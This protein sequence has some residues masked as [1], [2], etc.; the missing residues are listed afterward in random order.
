METTLSPRV[1]VK[2][3]LKEMAATIVSRMGAGLWAGFLV[4]TATT[5]SEVEGAGTVCW[6][7][8]AKMCCLGAPAATHSPADQ[9]ATFCVA[10][11]ETTS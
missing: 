11:A 4:V 10:A 3:G 7:K 8:G 6:V 9:D 5:F 1:R 2:T